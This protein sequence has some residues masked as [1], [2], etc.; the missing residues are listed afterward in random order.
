MASPVG[1]I[2]Y[3]IMNLIWTSGQLRFGRLDLL[4]KENF[5]ISTTLPGGKWQL[6]I[7]QRRDEKLY[8]FLGYRAERSWF[9]LII[10]PW[11]MLLGS[12]M[13]GTYC[14]SMRQVGTWWQPHLSP[15]LCGVC[16]GWSRDLFGWFSCRFRLWWIL[17]DVD[18]LMLQFHAPELVAGTS[19]FWFSYHS[20]P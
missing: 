4:G 20:T 14:Y 6:V 16:F 12:G 17:F 5:V 8:E 2:K 1:L 11:I 13:L 7:W 18:C 10:G 19:V 9:V 15:D 3:N